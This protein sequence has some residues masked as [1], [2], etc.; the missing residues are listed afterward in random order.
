[1]SNYNLYD[2][3]FE[4]ICVVNKSNEIV[5]YNH[6]FASF[7]KKSPRI[8]KKGPKL[9]SLFTGFEIES[10]LYDIQGVKVGPEVEIY[11]DDQT[12]YHVIIKA[13]EA[14]DE[15]IVCFNDI[16][17]EKNLY[18]K[19]RYQIEELKEIHNQIIQADKLSTIG[20][21]TATISHEISN[22]LTIASGNLELVDA[23]ISNENIESKDLITGSIHDTKDSIDRIT[24]IIKGLKS[25]LHNKDSNKKFIS[26]EKVV[27]RSLSLLKVPLEQDGIKV[28]FD[29]KSSS[30]I[31]ANPIEMEQVIINLVTNAIHALVDAKVAS[32]TITITITKDDVCHIINVIDNGPGINAENK[33]QIFESFFTTKEVGEGTGLGLAISS[34]IIDSYSGSLKLVDSDS[35]CNFEITLPKMETTSFTDSEL[36]INLDFK[37]VLVIDN[38]PQILNLF[39]KYFKDGPVN[40]IFASDAIEA[41][42]LLL[43]T[44]VDAIITDYDM[45]E[46][47]GVEFA[48]EL[49][50]QGDET[51]V[52]IMS[53]VAQ[54]NLIAGY[55]EIK[56]FLEKPFEKE[57]ILDLLGIK[58]EENN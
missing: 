15:K 30:I 6:Y 14:N 54:K 31:L 12:F 21:I 32:P 41:Q 28:E 50:S 20:E 11:L 5:Y 48:K 55:Q 19:Y 45:P 3:I 42:R 27:E 8:L 22:P 10:F 17:I 56:G 7:F 26:V 52:F 1:M 18:T 44:N 37:R 46:K 53:G 4:P 2:S 36:S 58:S 47:N 23:L 39:A 49:A 25:F 16:S 34:K 38:E 33:D 40:L 57:D 35:G 51:P 13:I 29:C 43:G 9:R 24:K